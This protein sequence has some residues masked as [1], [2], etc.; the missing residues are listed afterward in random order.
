MAEGDRSAPAGGGAQRAA[1]APARGGRRVRLD[2]DAIVVAAERVV[3]AEGLDALSMR[4]IGAELGADPTALYRHFRN[5]EEL[6][7]ELAGR[8]FAEAP[9]LD[10]ADDWRVRLRAE[11]R[12]E[13]ERYRVHPELATL[14]ARQPDDEP[15][16]VRMNERLL[17]ILADAGLSPADAARLFHVIENFVVGSGLYAT[18]LEH[19]PDPRV[20]DRAA[21]RRVYAGLDGETLPHAAAAAPHLF[22]PQ[23]E[24]F[25][26]GVD[27]LVAAIER[28]AAQ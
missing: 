24:I 20:A 28:A 3:S 7:V 17:A 18:L 23:R 5:K 6:L 4:R 14:I 27:L 25:E 26:A 10:P 21:M 19:A 16:L 12:H 8:S 11:L 1:E 13:L 9:A 2:R 15:R 22:P